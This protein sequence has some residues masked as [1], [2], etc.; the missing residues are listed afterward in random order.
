MNE[1][2]SL[3]IRTFLNMKKSLQQK[4][5]NCE[6]TALHTLNFLQLTTRNGKKKK[7]KIKLSLEATNE[8]TY[9]HIF[10]TIRLEIN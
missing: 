5:E 2:N 4:I 9:I 7:F 1:K 8:S 3:F 10:D 6:K